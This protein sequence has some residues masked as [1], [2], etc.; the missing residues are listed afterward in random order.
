MRAGGVG[1]S[2]AVSG[3][4]REGERVVAGLGAWPRGGGRASG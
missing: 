4:G 1:G 3:R 2:A